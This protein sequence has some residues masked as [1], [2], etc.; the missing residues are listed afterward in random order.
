MTYKASF[1]DFLGGICTVT[2]HKLE[3]SLFITTLMPLSTTLFTHK[4][5]NLI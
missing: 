3:M 1:I 5:N 4:K 2:F